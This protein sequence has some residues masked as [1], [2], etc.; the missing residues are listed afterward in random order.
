MFEDWK[1]AWRDAVANFWRELD[2]AGGAA[3]DAE[4][5]A[6]MRRDV[7]AARA[8]LDRVAAE[9]GRARDQLAEERQAEQSCRRRE[10]LARGIGDDE[11][12]RIAAEYAA[13]HAERAGVLDRKVRAIEDELALRRRDVEEMESALRAVRSAA[14]APEVGG[15]DDPATAGDE[16][17]EREFRRMERRARE[18][19]AERRLEELKRGMR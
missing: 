8:E 6:A 10:R 11:T 9:L 16:A 5:I 3:A 14:A 4:R 13:R 19:E 2:D 15:V 12:A 1:Q 18:R 7:R 17:A